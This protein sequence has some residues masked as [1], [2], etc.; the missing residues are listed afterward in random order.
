MYDLMFG[1]HWGTSIAGCLCPRGQQAGK[2]RKA[3]AQQPGVLDVG[4]LSL[5][6]GFVFFIGGGLQ[7]Y[8]KWHYGKLIWAV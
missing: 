4:R 3:I 5:K 7:L 8:E 6:W 1:S 2:A